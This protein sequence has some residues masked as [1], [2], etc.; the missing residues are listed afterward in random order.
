LWVPVA[1]VLA[2]AAPAARA[3]DLHG[4]TLALGHPATHSEDTISNGVVRSDVPSMSRIVADEV[5]VTFKQGATEAD[6]S[7]IR[8]HPG[9]A[10]VGRLMD[11]PA[12]LVRIA[13]SDRADVIAW[14]RALPGVTSVQSDPIERPDSEI[15]NDPGFRYQW[16]LDNAPG[17]PPPPD[18]GTPVYG[19]DVGAPLAWSQTLGSSAV[20]IAIVDSGIDAGHPDLAGKVVAAANFTASNTTA[21]LSG[22]GTHVAG[23]AAASFD[24]GTGIAG[25]A[26]NARLMDVKVLAIDATGQST[27]DCADVADGIVWAVD[28]GANVINLSLGSAAPCPVMAMALEYAFSHGALPIAAAGNSATTARSYP[29]ADPNVVSVAATDDDDRLATFSNRSADWVDVAAPGV[30]IVSTLPT[31]DNASGAVRYGYLSG[32]SMAA[33]IVSGIAA[34]IWSQMPAGSANR[35]V[36]ARLFGSADAIPGTGT[37][38]RY[39]RVD[40]C[41]AVTA[42]GPLCPP[43][44]SGPQPAPARPSP[45]PSEIG[46]PA[47][48]QPAPNMGAVPGRYLG[49]L[50][51]RGGTIRLVVAGRGDA[52]IRVQATIQLRC[53]AGRTRKVTLSALNTTDYGRIGGAGKFRI[54]LTTRGKIL[55]P[56]QLM[57]SGRFERSHGRARGTLRVSGRVAGSGGC[58]SGQASWTA[59]LPRAAPA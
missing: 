3:A 26:P 6:L 33:P 52:L 11:L 41:R 10:T 42:N 39:G 47:P 9:V 55:R 54:R 1:L 38:W 28:N 46:L 50:A 2:T 16:Y 51:R 29:A 14:L 58:D 5:V 4:G 43:V 27:G 49:S 15:P 8:A 32:T 7:R 23:I 22:H 45:A 31:Y 30:D 35:D 34:L 57:L 59:R 17:D 24:N 18:G 21:D 36:E 40:A 37:D 56:Q 25:M 48:I 20:R 12:A 13:P 19:A 44:T 53:P